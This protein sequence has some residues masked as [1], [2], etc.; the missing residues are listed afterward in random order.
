MEPILATVTSKG[1]I[2]IPARVRKDLGV[3]PGSRILFAPQKD[4]YWITEE[5]DPLD[6]LKGCIPHGGAAVTIE[7]M[8]GAMNKELERRW[9]HS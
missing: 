8:D 6:E 2:T 5:S 4:G 3:K 9:P 1:Q 7:E